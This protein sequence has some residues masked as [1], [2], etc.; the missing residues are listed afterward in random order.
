MCKEI[1]IPGTECESDSFSSV[2][3]I[4]QFPSVKSLSHCSSA[5][6]SCMSDPLTNSSKKY[7]YVVDTTDILNG[8]DPKID[9]RVKE[10]CLGERSSDDS[11]KKKTNY[12]FFM[13][14]CLIL[15]K[16]DLE[17]KRFLN[18]CCESLKCNNNEVRVM[19]AI[20]G[21]MTAAMKEKYVGK[22]FLSEIENCETCDKCEKPFLTRVINFFKSNEKITCE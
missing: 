6:I 4:A 11:T 16:K 21:N 13:N 15:E 14:E 8:K 10:N 2:E 18:E 9:K 5:T 1:P 3:G 12:C 19:R 20:I 22:H 17:D 7:Y